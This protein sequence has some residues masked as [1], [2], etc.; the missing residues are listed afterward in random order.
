[1]DLRNVLI[2]GILATYS[3]QG[4]SIDA[5]EPAPQSFVWSDLSR[6]VSFPGPLVESDSAYDQKSLR[7]VANLAHAEWDSIAAVANDS[8]FAAV[9][10]TPYAAQLEGMAQLQ[11][12]HKTLGSVDYEAFNVRGVFNQGSQSHVAYVFSR[13]KT[14]QLDENDQFMVFTLAW[15]PQGKLTGIGMFKTAWPRGNLR[16]IKPTRRPEKFHFYS[17]TRIGSDSAAKKAM[18]FTEA[19]YRNVLRVQQSLL[20]DTVEYHDGLGEYGIYSRAEVLDLLDH[21]ATDHQHHLIRY[22]SVIPWTMLR[23][24]R[25][26]AVV[27]TYEDWQNRDGSTAVYSFCRLY[28]FD[29]KGKINNFVFTR[30]REHPVGRYP[31][32]D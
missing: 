31:L 22:T 29:E 1:M 25:E 12:W 4:P 20:A 10:E 16:P 32:V 3:C 21:R 13:W 18:D 19:I 9:A 6:P 23:F 26:M 5:P 17:A 24:G 14:S 30:R 8:L 7:I 11:A 2:F 15:N 28:F 27:V